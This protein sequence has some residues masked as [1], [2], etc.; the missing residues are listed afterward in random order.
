MGSP[1]VQAFIFAVPR[2]KAM[3]GSATLMYVLNFSAWTLIH[4]GNYAAANALVDEF[5]ALKDETGSVFWGAWG[6]MQ[7]VAYWP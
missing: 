5:S 3:L 1:R 2:L 6:M 7:R 4:C